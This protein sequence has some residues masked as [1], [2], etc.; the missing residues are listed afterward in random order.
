MPE[1]TDRFDELADKIDEAKRTVRA[2]AAQTDDE[3]Q[4][5][6]D[7]ARKKADADAAEL[8]VRTRATAEGAEAHWDQIQSDWQRHRQSVRRRIDQAKAQQDLE[9]A[10]LRAEWA[11]ADAADAVDFAANAIDEAT[12]AMLAAIRASM[13]VKASLEAASQPE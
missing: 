10:V 3:L 1:F 12:Y 9:G 8:G 4:A 7:E 2:A 11:E 5:K 13:D 6:L